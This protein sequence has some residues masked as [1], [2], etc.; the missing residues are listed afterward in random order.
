M[1]ATM[2]NNGRCV[3]GLR[4][5]ANNVR[6][7]FPESLPAIDLELDHLQ[8]RCALGPDFWHAEPQISDPRLCSW[9]EA[10]HPN[11]RNNRLPVA[12]AMIPAGRNSFR[13]KLVQANGRGSAKPPDL[14]EPPRTAA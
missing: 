3:T 14:H 13:L 9:L 6:R 10:K 5:G 2:Q 4:V 1:L 8:I 7:Y 12:V 11:D